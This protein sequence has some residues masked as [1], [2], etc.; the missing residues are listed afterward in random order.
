MVII[1]TSGGMSQLETWDP[2]PDAPEEIR[3]AFGTIATP[4]AGVR[5]GEH[6]PRVASL[7]HRYAIIRTIS[8]DDVDHGSAT[9]LALTGRFHE[10][11]SSNP[12]PR[13]IDLPTLGAIVHRVR[14]ARS[15]PSSAVHINGPLLAPELAAP[16]QFAGLLGRGCEPLVLGDVARE[17]AIVP[18]LEPL[19]DVPTVRRRQRADLL[20]AIDQFRGAAARHPALLDMDHSYRAAYQF[21]DSEAGRRAF[22]LTQEPAALRERYGLYRSGQA[23]LLARRLVEAG[24]PY[25]TVFFNHT[26]RGQD[27]DPHDTDLYGWDTHN[28]IFEALEYHLL[29]RFDRSFAALLLDLQQRGLLEQTLVVCMGEFGRAPLVALEPRFAGS[30]PGRKHWAA[31]YSVVLAGAG[32]VGGTVVGASDRAAAYPR[33]RPIPPWDINATI[34]NA[35]GIDPAGHYFDNENRPYPICDGTPIREAY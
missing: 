18:G 23:C 17:G 13:P 35:L 12:L 25:I 9:Y 16:G 34:V 11:K 10:R 14:P 2:K 19:P 30:S 27:R 1:F 22:D 26:I 8:H 6:L 31:T 33:T 4:I 29:P 28:D 7:A 32:I 15:L 3:G 24:V 21:L 5:L 20:T